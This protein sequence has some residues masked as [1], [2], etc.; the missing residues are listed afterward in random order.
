[1]SEHQC[2]SCGNILHTKQQ[3]CQYC[4]T[5]N[6][7]Y[8]VE[9]PKQEPTRLFQ[10]IAPPTGS[11]TNTTTSES[12]NEGINVCILILLI[13]VFWPAAIVYAIVKMKN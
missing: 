1:M 10:P 12:T 13:I 11:N 2:K 8:K 7:I 3:K 6:P 4:G 9:A 5:S